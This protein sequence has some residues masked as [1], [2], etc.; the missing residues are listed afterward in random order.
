MTNLH[1]PNQSLRVHDKIAAAILP[2]TRFRGRHATWGAPW[3]LL[4]ATPRLLSSRTSRRLAALA[5][6]SR[7]R[8]PEVHGTECPLEFFRTKSTMQLPCRIHTGAVVARDCVSCCKHT[9]ALTRAEMRA[10]MQAR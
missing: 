2:Y 9:H 5:G 10:D 7:A 8:P 6:S 1:G 4:H 3:T